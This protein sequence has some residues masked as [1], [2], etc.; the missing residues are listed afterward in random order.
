MVRNTSDAVNE[1]CL[2]FPETET[3]D[4]HS[5]ANFRVA[6]KTFAIY[7]INHHGDGRVALWLEAPTGSQPLYVEMEPEHYFIPPYLGHKGWLGVHLNTG[8]SWPAVV[9]R[10]REAFEG[11]VELEEKRGRRIAVVS[12]GMVCASFLRQFLGLPGEGEEPIHWHNTSL[13]ILEY[14]G[15]WKVEVL[16]DGSHIEGLAATANGDSATGG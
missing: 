3:V 6:G 8:L 9:N 2:G 4:S 7:A 10:V 1:I 16:N 14:A 13:S 11:L 12:H 15:E 5:M